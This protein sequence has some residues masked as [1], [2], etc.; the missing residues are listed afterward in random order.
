MCFGYS[1]HRSGE[2]DRKN[3]VSELLRLAYGFVLLVRDP[4]P[5]LSAP[6]G[7]WVL[8]RF[9]VLLRAFVTALPF[10]GSGQFN[11]IQF[12]AVFVA[13][14]ALIRGSHNHESPG[15]DQRAPWSSATPLIGNG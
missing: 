4:V 7:V 8:P 10:V 13:L 12:T 14:K 2:R 6:V 1:N 5:E 9:R 3:R 11:T 15:F